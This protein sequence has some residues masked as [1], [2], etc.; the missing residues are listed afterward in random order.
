[1]MCPPRLPAPYIPRKAK[2]NLQAKRVGWQSAC[3]DIPSRQRH[4]LLD[5]A[6]LMKTSVPLLTILA[7]AMASAF[8]GPETIIKQRA[9]ELRDQNNVRQGVTPPTQ[10]PLTSTAPAPPSL[11][12]SLVRFQTDLG[13]LTMGTSVTPDQKQKL[14]QELAAAPQGAKP[15]TKTLTKLTDDLTAAFAEKPLSPTSRARLVQELD[16]VLNPGKYPQAKYDKI[17]EDVQAIF[18]ENGLSRNKAVVIADDV[19]AVWAEIQK[20]GAS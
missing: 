6:S 16:A 8:A 4:R 7:L 3:V 14:V 20:G 13:N 17:F 18:Q 2:I 11:S 1:M 15:S 12:P 9:K 5:T 10:A 19:K